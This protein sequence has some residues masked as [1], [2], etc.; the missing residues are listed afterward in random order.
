MAVV[1]ESIATD[2]PARSG[3]R[4]VVNDS[5]RWRDDERFD[6]YGAFYQ[7]VYGFTAAE[8]VKVGRANATLVHALQGAG[9]WSDAPT[10]NLVIGVML[11]GRPVTIC[12]DLGAGRFRSAVLAG[13]SILM[14]PN[15]GGSIQ[16]DAEHVCLALAI[17]YVTALEVMGDAAILPA[18]GDFGRLHADVNG[19]RELAYI[20]GQLWDTRS[21][22]NGLYADGLILQ[23]LGLLAHRA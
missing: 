18:D 9:D 6:D 4:A 13:N 10:P 5:K 1:V 20:V 12:A 17:P 19:D 15:T 14:P 3:L 23:A 11:R 22:A 16:M 8:V 21:T 7:Q 2:P